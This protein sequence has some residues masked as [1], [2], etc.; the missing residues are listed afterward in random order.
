MYGDTERY[1]HYYNQNIFDLTL[2]TGVF[3][4]GMNIDGFD[5]K[6]DTKMFPISGGRKYLRGGRW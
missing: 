3:L 6:T 1:L 2:L 5:D 4:F